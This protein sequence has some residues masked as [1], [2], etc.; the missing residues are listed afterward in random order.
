MNIL[1]RK[2]TS[3]ILVLILTLCV[4]FCSGCSDINFSDGTLIRPPRA[5]G[6]KAEIQDIITEEAGG[7]YT[8]KYPQN[9]DYRSAIIMYESKQITEC[10]IALYSTENDANMHVSIIKYNGEKWECAGTFSNSG[11]GVDCVMFN[12]INGDKKDE[13][14]IGWSTYNSNLKT[15][16][17]YTFGNNGIRE[18]TIDDT[19]DEMVIT[20]ITGNNVKDIILFSLS[21]SDAPST[22]KLLQY[23]EQEKRPIGKY[24]LELDSNITRFSNIMVGNVDEDKN[25]TIIEGEK[26]GGVFATQVIYFNDKENALVNPLVTVNNNTVSNVT[27]RKDIIVSRDV[28]DD[29]I[30][31]VPVVTQMS[32]SENDDISTICSITSWKQLAT[33]ENILETDMNTVIN[34]TDGYYFI[35]PEKWN[36]TV[37]AKTD[38]DNRQMTFYIWSTNTNSIGDKLL[39]IYRFTQTEWD[40]IDKSNLIHLEDVS[41][42]TTN[43]VFAAEIFPTNAKDSLNITEDE[44]TCSVKPIN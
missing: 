44:V 18:M 19:Y 7:S 30:I 43:A 29:G 27:T 32:A 21:T 15:L 2:N 5:T 13:I 3:R 14:I 12:D 39:T 25:G 22:A 17:A 8:L 34:Y 23:S 4:F 9:G 35:M 10:A 40:N 6:D 38:P 36:G 24:S 41:N 16:T 1:G 11:A 33:E 26:S 20:D 31:E 28:D 42:S 37:T